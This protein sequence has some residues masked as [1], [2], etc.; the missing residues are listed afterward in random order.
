MDQTS[1]ILSLRAV[2]SLINSGGDLPTVLQHLVL[3]ACRHANWTM[4]SIMAVDVE[5]GYALV[6]VRHD[7]TLIQRPLPDR[8]ELATSPSMIA[9]QRNEPVYIRDA[10]VSEDFPGYRRE[11]FE[12]DYRT[13]LVMPMNCADEDGRPMVLSVTSRDITEV[14]DED[15]AFIGMIV[16]LGEI[17]VDKQHRLRAEKLAAERLQKALQ[18][19]TTLLNQVLADGAVSSLTPNIRELLPHPAVVV[20]FTANL[21]VADRAPEESGVDD[22]AW[23]AAAGTTLSRPLIKAARDAVDHPSGGAQGLFL[24]IAG[25]RFRTCPQVE[26][27]SVDGEAVGALMIFPT[28]RPFGQLD[29]LLLDSIKFALNIQMMRSVIRFRYETRTFTELFLELVEGRW[30]DA[31]DILQR[32]QRLG[33]NL[34]VPTQ[35]IVV[36]VPER[37]RSL[38][39]STADFHHPMLRL[40]QQGGIQGSVVTIAGGFVC[41]IPF[42]GGK[43]QETAKRLMRQI[44]REAAHSLDDEPVVVL[45]GRCNTLGDYAT[46]W[47]R[48]WRM[49]RIARAFGRSG[50]LDD[51]D[52]GPLPML[53]AAANA[54]EV[55]GFVT[56][57]LGA[58]IDHDRQHGTPYLETLAAYLKEGCRSKAC[59]DTMGLHVTTLRYRLARISELFGIDVDRPERRFAV[60][61]AIHLRGVIDGGKPS[62]V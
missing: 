13:V 62:G 5:H 34:G 41:L 53:V 2:A 8:W 10:R 6:M 43:G 4:G 21:V 3:A 22:A 57:S 42:E 39:S 51:Q 33:L 50:A 27:L 31:R 35:M 26:P 24:E 37:N 48:S 28:A 58:L 46:S 19:H 20:D 56:D 11:A 61:L 15:L 45:G 12:R 25:R 18:A 52:F 59:A 44:A 40:M 55:R 16:H 30:R 54:D 29:R 36:E 47:E 60:E 32:A 49:I 23:Q 7:P 17:A 14:S 1:R 38:V 9:L